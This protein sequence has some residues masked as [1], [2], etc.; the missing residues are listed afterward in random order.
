MAQTISVAVP[1]HLRYLANEEAPLAGLRV[2]VKDNFS[3]QGVK[4]SLCNCAY[5]KLYPP[6]T[7]TAGCIEILRQL[8]CCH[9]W[10]YY[11]IT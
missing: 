2:A 10:N 8:V 11:R 1:S 5:Y 4:K 3:I 6:S 7:E 9:C